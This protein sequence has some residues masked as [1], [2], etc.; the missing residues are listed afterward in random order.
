MKITISILLRRL[1]EVINPESVAVMNPEIE[2]IT[3]SHYGSPE[4]VYVTSKHK[5]ALKKLTK[6]T[7]LTPA[8][9]EALK[10]LGFK[11][12]RKQSPDLS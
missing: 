12:K 11:F 4:M 2:F 8:H 1:A 5:E 6:T 9:V 3:K 7:T 10:E